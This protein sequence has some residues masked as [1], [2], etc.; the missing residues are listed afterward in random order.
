MKTEDSSLCEDVAKIKSLLQKIVITGDISSLPFTAQRI[1]KETG[2]NRRLLEFVLK[3][4][5][6][7]EVICPMHQN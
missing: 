7:R 5:D 6:S 3:D 1:G 4:Y 2:E